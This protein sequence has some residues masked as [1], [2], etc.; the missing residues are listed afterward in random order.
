MKKERLSPILVKDS[1][2]KKLKIEASKKDATIGEIVEDLIK[3]GE[4]KK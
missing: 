1:I 4:K 3:K 2:R